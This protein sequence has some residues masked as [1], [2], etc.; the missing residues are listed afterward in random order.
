MNADGVTVSIQIC[1]ELL[2]YKLEESRLVD[3]VTPD[4]MVAPIWILLVQHTPFPPGHEDIAV[5]SIASRCLYSVWHATTL[6]KPVMEAV[7]LKDD[8][9]LV[10]WGQLHHC[11]RYCQIDQ[12]LV[13]DD[14]RLTCSKALAEVVSEIYGE[15]G[16]HQAKVCSWMT[17]N[18]VLGLYLGYPCK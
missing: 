2:A 1:E 18:P 3:A 11:R 5:C 17:A 10:Y 7:R 14:N 16:S 12:E 8:L 15:D 4:P 6:L 13:V 9:G